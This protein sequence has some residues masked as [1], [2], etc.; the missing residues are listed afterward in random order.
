MRNRRASIHDQA[1][2]G[3]LSERDHLLHRALVI[4]SPKENADYW[5]SGGGT[6]D[7]YPVEG[8]PRQGFSMAGMLTPTL[9]GRSENSAWWCGMANLYWWC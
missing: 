7:L 8:D 5:K 9:T 6:A 4:Q 3:T 2:D 1:S